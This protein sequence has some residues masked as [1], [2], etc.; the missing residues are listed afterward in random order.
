L[1]KIIYLSLFFFIAIDYNPSDRPDF[2][3]L[4]KEIRKLYKL[5]NSTSIK[6]NSSSTNI[7]MK[8]NLQNILSME[9]AIKNINHKDGSKEDAWKTFEEY[10]KFDDMTAKYWK[11][12]CLFY[13][14]I[15][16]SYEKD[17][18][19]QQ[20]AKLFKETADKGDVM[21]A[22]FQYGNCLT[23]GRGVE[24]NSELALK[25]FSKAADKGHSPA[26]YNL[27]MMQYKGLG[28]EV[29]KDEGIYWM[30]LAA[31]NDLAAAIKF[32]KENSI[33]L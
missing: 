20:A 32:C 18:R 30:K 26:M 24:K 9:E 2:K 5:N 31:Y 29:N 4:L 23:N 11:G 25:Y 13:N 7:I 10:A 14:L 12:H 6:Q 19:D 16:F 33:P 1:I 3:E 8:P 15:P 27:G 17:E 22:Q 21:L 28:I